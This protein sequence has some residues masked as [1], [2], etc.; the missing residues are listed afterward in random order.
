M[1]GGRA[2]RWLRFATPAPPFAPGLSIC[3]ARGAGVRRPIVK[4]IPSA[5]PSRLSAI[6]LVAILLCSNRVVLRAQTAVS[7]LAQSASAS[8]GTIGTLAGGAETWRRTYSFSTGATAATFDFTGVTFAFNHANGS[9][10]ALAVDLYATF[11]AST[12]AGGGT[13]L[14]SLSLSSGNPAAAGTASFAGSAT[15]QAST[16]YYL[17][18][19]SAPA[20]AANNYNYPIA[21]SFNEDAGGLAGW[22]IFDGSWASNGANP[23]SLYSDVPQ[24]S[25]QASASAIPEPS[26]YAALAGAAMLGLAA[27]HRRKRTRLKLALAGLLA[28]AVSSQAQ[29]TF[30]LPSTF[31]NYAT[32]SVANPPGGV[33]ALGG[34]AVYAD[35]GPVTNAIT[36]VTFGQGFTVA[37]DGT[38]PGGTGAWG[39]QGNI[40]GASIPAATTIPISYSFTLGNNGAI[41]SD[42]DWV[43][44]FRG[45]ANSE[46]QIASGTLAAP[47]PGVA[48]SATFSGN[49][50][51]YTFTSGA[52]AGVDTYRAYLGLSFTNNLGAMMPGLLTVTMADNGFQGPGITLNA[53]AIPEPSTYAALLGG[54]GL[55]LAAWRRKRGAKSAAWHSSLSI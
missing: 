26:T 54:A 42:V 24:F 29:T 53:S 49:A 7:N 46:I 51:S 45:G 31:A 48:T 40:S 41:T 21:A 37:T 25:V 5:R 28:G 4:T 23:W 10:G 36:A 33:A 11:N 55:A 16:T 43:L 38:S 8:V 39:Y 17:L 35:A 14:A 52:T 30:D 44:Y 6:A 20:P 15:L 27:W 13:L 1:S 9:P 19:S 2:G 47:T 50:A 32:A 22:S 12:V 34:S 3:G 18:L